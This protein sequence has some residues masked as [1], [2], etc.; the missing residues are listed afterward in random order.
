[1][2]VCPYIVVSGS[3]AQVVGYVLEAPA[4]PFPVFVLG[5]AFNGFGVALQVRHDY[6]TREFSASYKTDLRG[7]DAGA[8]AFVAS[9]KD[10]AS[11]K[12]GILHA[13]Y[14]AHLLGLLL[15]RDFIEV[16]VPERSALRWWR[17]SSRS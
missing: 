14:G 2:S 6:W 15:S 3:L 17:R 16:Q 7:Q 12:M 8:N 11:T 13:V 9:L 4:P 1:M 5:Y 10:N